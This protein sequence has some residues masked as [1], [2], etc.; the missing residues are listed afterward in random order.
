M[1]IHQVEQ[2]SHEWLQLRN[3]RITGTSLKRLLGA[4]KKKL[5]ASVI[6]S[7]EVGFDLDDS[8]S[9]I[10]FDMQ[11]GTDQEPEAQ[12]VYEAERGIKLIKHGFCQHDTKWPFFGMSPDYDTQD[13]EGAL[14]IKC[15]STTTH[16]LTLINKK[17]PKDNLTQV[18]AYFLVN[19]NRKWI[20]FM[21]YDPRFKPQQKIIIRTLR[22]N[23]QPEITAIE[24]LLDKFEIDLKNAITDL[25]F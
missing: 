3:G 11:W 15:P 18:L 17:V 9:Y 14:E 6:A 23:V 10:S 22:E 13:S 24:I 4:D 20:D 25:T 12:K 19:Q 16:V 21:S 1:K 5:L 2:G 7:H 8:D